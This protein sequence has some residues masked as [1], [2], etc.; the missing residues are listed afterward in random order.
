MLCPWEVTVRSY[1]WDTNAEFTSLSNL[2]LGIQYTLHKNFE[3]NMW[4]LRSTLSVDLY[5]IEKSSVYHC[6]S[7]LWYHPSVPF[8]QYRGKQTELNLYTL[9][10][11]LSKIWAAKN[12]TSVQISWPTKYSFQ[13][14]YWSSFSFRWYKKYQQQQRKKNSKN[15]S[16]KGIVLK[17]FIQH[18]I[19]NDPQYA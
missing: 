12:G 6:L 18:D 17:I 11:L 7:F 13:A 14:I 4:T 9:V 10:D 2:L 8:L 15:K 3:K 19:L 16:A 1:Y 5:Q